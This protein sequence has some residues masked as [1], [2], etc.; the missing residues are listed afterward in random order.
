MKNIATSNFKQAPRS[1]TAEKIL[2]LAE[3]LIQTRGCSAFS[4][5][6][7]SDVLGVRKAGIHYH[8]EFKTDLGVAVVDRYTEPFGKALA[9]IAGNKSS[10]SMAMLIARYAEF[11]DTPDR[12]CLCGALAGEI[13]A[14]LLKLRDRVDRFFTTH[15]WWLAEIPKRAVARGEFKLSGSASKTA[16]LVFAALQG[17]LVVRRTTAHASQMTDIISAL[18]SQLASA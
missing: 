2:D 11:A 14:L 10:S 9:N 8:F 5:K 17:A 16:R 15:Q 3:M 18:K 1:E 7:I 6:D 13:P 4:Y 12:V